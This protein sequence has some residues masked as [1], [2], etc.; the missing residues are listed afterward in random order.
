[1]KNRR[2]TR[3]RN[4]FI[5]KLFKLHRKG[6][7]FSRLDMCIGGRVNKPIILRSHQQ[8]RWKTLLTAFHIVADYLIGPSMKIIV[9]HKM[10]V[11]STQSSFFR[12]TRT[13]Q[14]PYEGEKHRHLL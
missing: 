10:R 6:L 12:A 8:A 11:E 7:S 2:S 3:R 13:F 14:C 5:Y 4:K 1:M 9:N